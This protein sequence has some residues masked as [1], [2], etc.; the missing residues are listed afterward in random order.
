MAQRYKQIKQSLGWSSLLLCAWKRKRVTLSRGACWSS[1]G[2]AADAQA[3]GSPRRTRR[4]RAAAQHAL[5]Q[6]DVL[7]EVPGAEEQIAYAR[8][9][10]C[11]H[12]LRVV[13]VV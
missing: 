9:R 13:G 7:A 2:G 1:Q 10:R 5:E 11:A 6:L 3:A 8:L 4:S 12:A